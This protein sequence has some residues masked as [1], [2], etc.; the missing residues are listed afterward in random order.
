MR[1]ERIPGRRI[2]GLVAATGVTLALSA[3]LADVASAQDEFDPPVTIPEIQDDPPVKPLGVQSGLGISKQDRSDELLNSG[4][5]QIGIFAA[6]LA[7][8]ISAI[9][10]T[11]AASR[12]GKR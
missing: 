4:E 9:A 8:G 5:F 7:I 2:A 1:I 12:S 3:G 6:G 10:S 11:A